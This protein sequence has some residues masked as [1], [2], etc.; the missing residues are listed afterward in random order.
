MRYVKKIKVHLLLT[1]DIAETKPK[2][3]KIVQDYGRLD[4][5]FINKDSVIKNA[6]GDE[7][8]LEGTPTN[9]FKWLKKHAGFVHGGYS[10]EYVTLEQLKFVVKHFGFER[11]E[12]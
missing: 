2:N 9:F 1:P 4:I 8:I 3:C 12:K 5:I 6:S 11:Y 7:V 10:W